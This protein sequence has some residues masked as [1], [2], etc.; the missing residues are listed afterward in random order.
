MSYGTSLII[1]PLDSA[2]GPGP[3]RTGLRTF[4][5]VP[6]DR[7]QTH[8]VLREATPWDLPGLRELERAAG[9]PFRGLGM[10]AVADDE[11]P[12][13]TE[14]SAFQADGRAWVCTDTDDVPVAYLLVDVIDGE[15]HIEQVSVH[16]AHARQRLGQRLIAHVET[17]ARTRGLASLTLTTFRGVA[18][19]APYYA[20]LGFNEIE[21][22]A[23]G[24][25]LRELRRKEADRGLD[26]WPRLAMRR[27]VTNL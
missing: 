23:L 18:W 1:R 17:W 3:T 26:R 27:D 12:S 21:E 16:P 20:R 15:A 5:A 8:D 13:I 10:G 14:L 22:P 25:G 6:P 9:A 2:A 19:N 24:P 7:M 4:G 11:P